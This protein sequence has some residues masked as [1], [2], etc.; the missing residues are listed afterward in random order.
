MARSRS[1]VSGV[2]CL[3]ALLCCSVSMMSAF[4][5]GPWPAASRNGLTTRRAEEQTVTPEA[6]KFADVGAGDDIVLS[7]DEYKM[8]LDQEI[9]SQRKKYYL[10]G[11]VK[12]TNLIVPWKPVDEGQLVKDAKAQLKQNG[13]LDPAGE[14]N[15]EDLDRDMTVKVLGDEDVQLEWTAGSAVGAKVG[16][17]IEK[18]RAKDTNFR[19]IMSYENQDGSALLAKPY[20]GHRYAYEDQMLDP[21]VWSYRVLVRERSGAIQVVDTQDITV[22]ER[23]GVTLEVTLVGLG[24]LGLLVAGGSALVDTPVTY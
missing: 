13:I 21:G 17:I 22:P 12:E 3:A 1:I 19:E 6:M 24:I 5:S 4:V 14:V 11:V 2:A 7:P 8:A 15:E 23:A 18:K 10:G 9:E 20:G 16:Y